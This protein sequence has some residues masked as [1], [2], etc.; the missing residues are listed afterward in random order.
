MGQDLCLEKTG[1]ILETLGA[2]KGNRVLVGFA[3]E[4]Q[5]LE[6]N[7]KAKLTAKNLDLIVANLVGQGASGFGSDTNQVSL[8]YRDGRTED[9]PL[10]DKGTLANMLLDRVLE[11]RK[12]QIRDA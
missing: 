3:A 2:K 10:M 11:I 9:L 4:T 5:D 6:E 1:D 7:A 12:G 8:L